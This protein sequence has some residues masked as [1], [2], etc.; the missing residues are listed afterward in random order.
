VCID[1]WFEAFEE[2]RWDEHDAAKRREKAAE[3]AAEHA[4]NAAERPRN[5]PVEVR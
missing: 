2:P 5:G 4:E 3:K 1:R